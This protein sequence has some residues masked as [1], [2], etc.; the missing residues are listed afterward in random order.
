MIAISAVS[1]KKSL[2]NFVRVPNILYK[3]DPH[4]RPQLMVERLEHLSPKN[5]YFKHAKHQ[6]FLAHKDGVLAGRISAQIDEL[7]QKKDTPPVGH[8]GFVDAADK[9]VLRALLEKAESWLREQG[10]E[11]IIG[12][13]SFSIND[14]AGLLVEGFDSPPRMMMNYAPEW[15][16]AALEK[17]GY[18]PVKDLLAF[19]MHMNID[20][21][22]TAQR[23]VSKVLTHDDVNFRMLD[24]ENLSQD[25]AVILE[26]FNEAWTKNWGF[27]PMT[28]DELTHTANS[29]KPIIK[30][31]LVQIGEVEG[32]PAAMIVALPDL[33]ESLDG[34]NG[35]LLPFGWLKLLWRLKV[36]G[37]TGARILLMGVRPQYQSGFLG[38]ALAVTVMTKLHDAMRKGGY[39]EAEL[40]W[41]LEDNAPM[42]RLVK[43]AGAK[44]YKRYRVYEKDLV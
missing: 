21:P 16:G 3:S 11:K 8:F 2:K 29:M 4:H 39:K 41:I 6:L 31:E 32:K 36:K 40:S 42:I 7:A 12:P 27:I 10:V 18:I 14:E 44:I 13:Y 37:V 17:A 34:L 43:S 38:A 20:I 22:P 5:P 9:E 35:K 25:L 24:K 23:I 28:A 1:D 15:L 19:R 30:P 33:N 26:I